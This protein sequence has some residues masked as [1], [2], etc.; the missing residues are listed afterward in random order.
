MT[1][2]LWLASWGL[3]GLCIGSFVN[4]VA[5]RLP[6][7]LLSQHD[8]IAAGQAIHNPRSQCMQCQRTLPWWTLLP[9]LSWLALKG[10]CAFCRQPIALGY[11]IVELL[12]GAWFVW[13]GLV[14][15]NATHAFASTLL[16]SVWGAL[17][18]CCLLIDHKY[19]LLPDVLTYSLLVMGLTA[20]AASLVGVALIAVSLEQSVLGAA[21]AWL[22]LAAV[23]WGYRAGTGRDGMGQGD[24]KL[25][26]ALG[27]WLGLAALPWVLLGASLAGALIGIWARLAKQQPNTAAAAEL[28]LDENAIAFGPFLVASAVLYQVLQSQAVLM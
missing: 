28:G 5:I 19:F 24:I 23:A 15:G 26:A 10:R 18:L 16:W 9:V 20:S 13:C 6:L 8:G 14:N 22:V 17:L 4:V 3:V 7:R 27:A 21:V 11:P 2:P 25:F 12:V 1:N